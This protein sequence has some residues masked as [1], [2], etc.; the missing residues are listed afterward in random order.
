MSHVAFAMRIPSVVVYNMVSPEY[1]MP[2]KT[3]CV[4]VV[5]DKESIRCLFCV[6]GM[7]ANSAPLC[8]RSANKSECITSIT[9]SDILKALDKLL[10]G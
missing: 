10:K 7:N 2:R 1:R 4:P 5:A 3:R 9:S 6:D 8:G